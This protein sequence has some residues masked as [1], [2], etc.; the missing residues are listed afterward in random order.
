[1]FMSKNHDDH[2]GAKSNYGQS[3]ENGQVAS[4]QEV[5]TDNE[6]R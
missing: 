3:V 6:Q 1:M 4:D 5:K 2:F